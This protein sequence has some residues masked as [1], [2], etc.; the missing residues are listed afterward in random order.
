MICSIEGCENLAERTGKCATHARLERK[1]ETTAKRDAEKKAQQ[2]AVKKVSDKMA[3]ALKEYGK[4]SKQ[5]LKENPRCV[6]FPN[7]PAIECHHAKGR[8]TIELLLDVTYFR[9]VSR[10]GHKWIHAHP[11][12]AI[13]RGFS[14]SRLT[15]EPHAI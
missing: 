5:F 15:D 9:A 1:A 4:L 7:L 11:Q 12:E 14:F 2:K 10:E 8:N 13:D 6:V 3:I